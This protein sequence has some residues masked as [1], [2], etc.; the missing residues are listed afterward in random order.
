MSPLIT[1]EVT[2]VEAEYTPQGT[3]VMVRGYALSYRLQTRRET[4]A[5]RNVKDSDIARELAAAHGI[6]VGQVDDSKVVH[7]HLPQLN[8]TDWE[9][10]QARAR[11]IGFDLR[12]TDSKLQFR[13]PPA[14]HNPAVTL[15]MRDNLE[16][17]HPRL[18][19]A[20]QA[21]GVTVRSWDP[22]AKKAVMGTGRPAT[23]SASVPLTPS[24]LAESA[25]ASGHLAADRALDT[26]TEAGDVAAALAE[27][28]ASSFLEAE[29]TA[30]GD[31]QLR[32]GACVAVARVASD[33]KGHCVLT[34]TRH[35]WDGIDGYKTHFVV[36]GRQERS[37]LGLAT[38]AVSNGP[39][40]APRVYGM[41]V[42]IVTNVKDPESLGR[43]K[44]KFPWLS[45]AYESDWVRVCQ[46]GA[47]KQRGALFLPEV[48]DEVLV[49]FEHGDVRRPYVL[50]GLY[51]GVDKPNVGNALIDDTSGAVKRRGIVSNHGHKLVFFDDAAK[52]GVALIS[53]GNLRV[54]LKDTGTTI[55]VSSGGTVLI[56]GK[57]VTVRAQEAL[58][59]ASDGTVA[60]EGK[61]I[62]VKASTEASVQGEAAVAV[63]GG[64]V[65]IN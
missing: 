11:E 13:K 53:A 56:E 14:A 8:L 18:S 33:F 2:A 12:V 50:G 60:I 21:S 25:H 30:R 17:F 15:T 38:G 27:R 41:V 43:A 42:A 36:S 26:Q 40:A 10:L 9:F 7:T 49:A 28:I 3:H 44:V 48:E 59:L 29:G 39:G 5:W 24:R 64:V 52:S 16:R 4:K 23:V 1:G 65:R 47:G 19:S 46:V 61:S 32:A 20:A 55:H 58:R 62:S 54:A 63:K 57:N 37:L 6:T 45:D 35:V 34:S 51:N 31:P 22:S